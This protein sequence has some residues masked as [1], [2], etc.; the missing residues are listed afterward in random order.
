MWGTIENKKIKEIKESYCLGEACLIFDYD[1]DTDRTIAF[2]TVNDLKKMKE[3]SQKVRSGQLKG[4]TGKSFQD[5][6]NIGIGGSDL[7]PRMVCE[8]L[9]FYAKGPQVHFVS[10]VD[11]TDIVETLKNLS[12][13]KTLF[14]VASKTFTTQETMTNAETAR[15]W[16][17]QKL[18]EKAV[19]N[20]FVAI[21][22]NKEKV[23]EFGIDPKNM[24]EFWDFVGGRYSV[25][26][27]IGLSVC[28]YLGFDLF[29]QLL[30]GAHQM[31]QHFLN[32]PLEKNI[33]V[34]LALI[35]IWN[36]NFLQASSHAI[37][38]YDQYLVKFSDYF[39]QADME[40]NGKSVDRNGKIEASE[41]AEVLSDLLF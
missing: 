38:P 18:G 12:P 35:G 27:A 31:D 25:W 33:P 26:S 29:V 20:H 4:V 22:T 8:A 41:Q 15:Q 11:G 23:M 2:K 19:Q 6:V 17:V 24:F 28:C 14:M 36:R 9:Q 30:E 21:S 40:S 16:L 3:F 32:T 34:I 39:Q 10:N 1:K 13:E 37:L 5:I 7:G